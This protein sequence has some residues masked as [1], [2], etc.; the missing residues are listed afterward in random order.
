MSKLQGILTKEGVLY[1]S[2]SPPEG[3]IFYLNQEDPSALRYY[4]ELSDKNYSTEELS[5]SIR[6]TNIFPL[7][8]SFVIRFHSWPFAIT[9]EL[10]KAHEKAHEF[11][12]NY[13]HQKT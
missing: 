6:E 10:D 5:Y 7:N 1:K 4:L 9:E 3:A 13:A 12:L 11:L 8:Q 2:Q